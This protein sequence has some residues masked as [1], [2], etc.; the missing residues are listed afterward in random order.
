MR[1][2]KVEIRWSPNAEVLSVLSDVRVLEFLQTGRL[3]G[4]VCPQHGLYLGTEGL[5][6]AGGAGL[7]V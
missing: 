3:Q 5:Q 4:G 7:G 6:R 2:R 1:H